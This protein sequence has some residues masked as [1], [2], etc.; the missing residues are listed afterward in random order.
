MSR[1]VL[2]GAGLVSLLLLSSLAG[3]GRGDKTAAGSG[4]LVTDVV[5]AYL[6]G[7]GGQSSMSNPGEL[8]QQRNSAL[9]EAIGAAL[10]SCPEAAPEL[11]TQVK[12]LQDL[13]QRAADAYA[14]GLARYR[15]GAVPREWQQAATFVAQLEAGLRALP[16]A[17]EKLPPADF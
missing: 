4:D 12:A 2:S 15:A 8:G 5:D 13:A 14:A 10:E 6:K 9:A 17:A 1:Y 3:C 11:K 16:G 7:M